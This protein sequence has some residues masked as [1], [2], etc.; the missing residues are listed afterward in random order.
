M[1]GAGADGNIQAGNI[2][3]G[4]DFNIRGG[5]AASGLAVGANVVGAF[6]H[7][8]QIRHLH[9]KALLDF[10]QLDDGKLTHWTEPP[11]S[12]L[13]QGL[14]ADAVPMRVGRI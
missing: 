12:S 2:R 14:T 9:E 6:G 11:S 5:L 10:I 8:M 7:L 4:G 3:L 1:L 13:R